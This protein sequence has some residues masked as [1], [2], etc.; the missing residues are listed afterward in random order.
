V[1]YLVR[2]LFDG[3]SKPTA[4]PIVGAADAADAER[5]AVE[6]YPYARLR[7]LS[8]TPAPRTL[9]TTNDRGDT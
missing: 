2:L 5:R 6:R 7:I 3:S 4:V 8:V 1:T 9:I